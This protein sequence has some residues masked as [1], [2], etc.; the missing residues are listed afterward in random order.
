MPSDGPA[1]FGVRE[2]NIVQKALG[3]AGLVYPGVTTV[4]GFYNA[5]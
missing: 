3:A 5:A 4:R 2:M 1:V